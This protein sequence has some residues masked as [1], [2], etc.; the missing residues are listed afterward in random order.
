M[1][2]KVLV[3]ALTAIIA[4]VLTMPVT[5][6]QPS[7]TPQSSLGTLSS[8]TSMATAGIFKNDV[9]NFM[10]YY[11]YGKVFKGDAKF[12]SF[13]TG[14]NTADGV[15]DAGFASNSGSS[16]LGVWYRG[17]MF[18]V[19][20]GSETHTITPTW[21]NDQEK[22]L[23]TTETTQYSTKW[24][25]SAN[26]IEFLFG[27][28]GHG[29]KVG[30]LE[31]LA[32]DQNPGSDTIRII[33]YKNGHKNHYGE[34]V[35]YEN[36]QGYLKPYLG[37]GTNIEMNGAKL[38][39]FIDLGL[40]IYNN[41]LVNN[42]RD[43]TEAQGVKQN[44]TSTV[45]AG[46]NQGFLRPYGVAGIR[47][48]IAGENT[49]TLEIKYGFDMRLENNNYDATGLSGDVDG[50]VTWDTGYVK[51]V[52]EHLDSTITST[53]IMLNIDKQS[54]MTHSITPTYK[55]TGQPAE[56]LN[57]GF[58]MVV[59]IT[60]LSLST[61]SYSDRYQFS[62]TDYKADNSLNSEYTTKTRTYNTRD[63]EL[64]YLS[65]G[66]NLNFGASY[67]LIPD[68][69]TIN[70]GIGASPTSYTHYEYKYLPNSV[71]S[72]STTKTTDSLGNV[73]ES[74]TV[75]Y[76]T[77]GNNNDTLYVYDRWGQWT[78]TLYGGFTFN[79]NSNATLDLGANS[80]TGSANTFNL[81]LTT[82]NVIFTFK[83]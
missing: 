58:S 12:F 55:V 83:F 24:Q 62:K 70:A 59:P 22:L 3:M 23:Q 7:N 28:A 8:N 33:D 46:G 65:I 54:E 14:R 63:T 20:D 41:T 19:S 30:F 6:Q 21:D 11:N 37:W 43:Y 45:G 27:M 26:Q 48:D 17:N 18:K 71:D 39:P 82:V 80:G 78:A 9:D 73:T 32:S 52:E 2:K 61:S 29:I 79:F 77:Q 44:I 15:L 4:L 74:K 49:T 13:L 57:L 35:T 67:K 81:D 31:W 66:L 47:V 64:S 25:E 60:I 68:R 56:G 1:Q 75:T 40:Q 34:T 38:I 76:D 51:R 72:V 53:D 50:T 16:Y 36:S 10:N 69:F 42:Y 5:A